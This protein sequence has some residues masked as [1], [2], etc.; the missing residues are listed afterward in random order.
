MSLTLAERQ[1]ISAAAR[2]YAALQSGVATDA[3]RAAW[4][5]WLLADPVHLQ[6]WQR[7]TAVAEQMASVPG[8]VAAPA[9]RGLERSR[10]QVL[11]SVMILVPAA[12]LGWLSWRSDT[13]QQLFADFRTT[14]GERRQF[15]LADGSSLWLNTDSAVNVRY[16][17]SQRLLDLLQGEILISTAPDAAQRPFKIHTRHGEVLAL[18]TRFIVRTHEQNAEVA[19]IEKAVEVR[20]ASAGAAIRVEAGQ[21]LDFNKRSSGAVQRSDASVGAWQQGSI[22]AVERPLAELLADLSRYRRGVLRCDPQIARMKV[23]GAFPVDDTDLA[24]TA[25]ESGLSLRVTRFSRY[26]VHVSAAAVAR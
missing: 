7:M 17:G 11:R 1:A 14:V 6:A 15:Q 3:E 25:L 24:L 18:G 13:P 8:A 21:R 12:S 4:N 26:W 20:T 10:R 9:L 2:W 23:S 16:D 5:A 22:I 19:V